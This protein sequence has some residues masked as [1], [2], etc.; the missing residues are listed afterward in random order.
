MTVTDLAEWSEEHGYQLTRREIRQWVVT[1]VEQ[2]LLRRT[3]K[4]Y[5]ILPVDEPPFEDDDDWRQWEDMI[6]STTSGKP[7]L[8][9]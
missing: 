9:R 6:L 3:G 2:R 5:E 8:G 1:A 7:R 4:R